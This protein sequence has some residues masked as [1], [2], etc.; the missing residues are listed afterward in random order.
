[1]PATADVLGPTLAARWHVPFIELL[2]PSR[3]LSA[4]FVS[5][6]LQLTANAMTGKNRMPIWLLDG[7]PANV[8]P[9]S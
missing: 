1:L 9:G 8:K 4:G 5:A 3:G 6:G 2:L 7:A